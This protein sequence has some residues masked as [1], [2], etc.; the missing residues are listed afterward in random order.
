MK[1]SAAR[2]FGQRQKI[3]N[4]NPAL[5]ANASAQLRRVSLDDLK[6]IDNDQRKYRRVKVQLAG[7]F[8]RQDQKEF[9]CHTN[10]VSAGGVS[11]SSAASCEPG[12]HVVAYMEEIGRVEGV[13]V[14]QFEGGFAIALQAS[15]YKR[16]KI[17]ASLTWLL[18]RHELQGAD[19]RRHQ[20]T[21]P[22][23]KKTTMRLESGDEII[24]SVLDLSLGGARVALEAEL[25]VGEVV[26]L[27]KSRGKV[28]RIDEES[29]AIRFDALQSKQSVNRYFI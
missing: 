27:G 20:R 13:V 15:T 18:N 2:S 26:F 22:G 10:D 11:F 5:G 29:V 4:R 6:Q 3:I 9:P 23:D 17:I 1:S 25:D 28:V 8:M 7:R 14:R 19:S 24:A 12:E 16:E 21:V